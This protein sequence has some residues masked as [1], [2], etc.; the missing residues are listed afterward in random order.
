MVYDTHSAHVAVDRGLFSVIVAVVLLSASTTANG[1]EPPA[2]RVRSTNGAILE[3]FEEGRARSTTFQA[4]LDAIEHSDGIVYLEFG[5][6]A[7]GHLNGC[8]LPF[9]ASTAS[10]RYV[11]IVVTPDTR[12]VSH[13]QL[14]ALIGHEL[15]HALEVLEH[16]DVVDLVTMEA[17]YRRLGTPIAGGQHGFETSAA[18][19]TGDAVLSELFRTPR[20]AHHNPWWKTPVT[21][22]CE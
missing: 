9:I 12:R 14:L 4:L 2:S 8:L 11:R 3:L 17:M 5:H 10:E 22:L 15:R 21:V 16:A 6:C 18:R 19:A 20:L 1:A 13:D 7:F